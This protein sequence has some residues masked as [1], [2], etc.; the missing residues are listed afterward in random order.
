MSKKINSALKVL[1]KALE[2][3]ADVVGGSAVSLKKAQRASAK[4]AAAAE[5]YVEAVQ[6]K[7][8][9]GSPF[10][11]TASSGLEDSTVA[12]LAAER[13]SI[14]QQLTGP[15]PIL[16]PDAEHAEEHAEEHREADGEAHEE[17]HHAEDHHKE[18]SN[19]ESD[20]NKDTDDDDVND[21]DRDNRDEESKAN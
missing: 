13:D 17:E 6:A 15:V 9:L 4:V 18:E 2:A 19:D 10:T 5:A 8:G 14:K 12:S 3:H 7:S 20:N 21:N 11:Q 16:Q 1:K